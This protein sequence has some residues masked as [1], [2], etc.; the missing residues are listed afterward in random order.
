MKNL[1]GFFHA[2]LML[3][4]SVLIACGGGGA[5]PPNPN[6]IPRYNWSWQNPLP[7]GETLNA[8]WVSSPTSVY[9]VG[10]ASQVLHWDGLVWKNMDIAATQWSANSQLDFIWGS[11]EN[12]IYAGGNGGLFNW[13]G[14]AWRKVDIGA[15]E[16]DRL[17][18]MH[19]KSAS[20]IYI[21]GERGKIYH[22]DGSSW[23]RMSL[24]LEDNLTAVFAVSATNIYAGTYGEL[25]HFDGTSWS[26]VCTDLEAR[27]EIKAIWASSASDV[28]AVGVNRAI[29]ENEPAAQ[30]AWH[31]DGAVWKAID[32]SLPEYQGAAQMWGTAANNVYMVGASLR[33]YRYDGST[34]TA[35]N[36]VNAAAWVYGVSG[37]AD[38]N[39]VWVVGE[40]G[41]IYVRDSAGEWTLLSDQP[42]PTIT[43]AWAVSNDKLYIAGS[44][45]GYFEEGQFTDIA[46]DPDYMLSKFKFVSEKAIYALAYQYDGEK[47][48]ATSV[49]VLKYDGSSWS[50]LAKQAVDDMSSPKAFWVV[51]DTEFHIAIE[52]TRAAVDQNGIPIRQQVRMLMLHIKDGQMST[53]TMDFAWNGASTNATTLLG[54]A[55]DKLWAI[56]NNNSSREGI[57]LY[58]DGTR[59]QRDTT[60]GTLK[61]LRALYGVASNDFYIGGDDVL[62]KY[63]GTGFTRFELPPTQYISG[64]W[65]QPS[66]YVYLIGTNGLF[67]D[68]QLLYT[69]D[70][71]KITS[72]TPVSV[73]RVLA[74]SGYGDSGLFLAGDSGMILKGVR[75]LPG[76]A[77]SNAPTVQTS[78][79]AALHAATG[80]LSSSAPSYLLRKPR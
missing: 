35:E 49:A 13:N 14:S 9:A 69:F 24:G 78:R 60:A 10:V 62:L 64:I 21:S 8:V 7:Q 59:W 11:A 34:W 47:M 1:T 4:T 40:L 51:S 18:A 74:I 28:Y 30:S 43:S 17:F 33:I 2:V 6:P 31:F 70:G 41:L 77:A 71:N 26:R 25:F 66:G 56:A 53:D 75:L 67:S 50:T 76:S 61:P 68:V 57:L 29:K 12:N 37:S 22:F 52:E 32:D 80:W 16:G 73:N 23:S 3:L 79:G 54:F 27:V 15:A 55:P 45:L 58:F 44:G 5:A 36:N 38:G 39:S 48:T 20:D 72:T 63:N 65:Y 42:R 19:A 46:G